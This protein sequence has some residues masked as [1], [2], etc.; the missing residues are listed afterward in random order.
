MRGGPGPGCPVLEVPAGPCA[1]SGGCRKSHVVVSAC[2]WASWER[3][4]GQGRHS[5]SWEVRALRGPLGEAGARALA[6]CA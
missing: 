3:E 6:D 5:P 4:A 2:D 1:Q